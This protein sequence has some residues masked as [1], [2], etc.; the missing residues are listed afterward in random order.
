MFVIENA[1]QS[2]TWEALVLT[3]DFCHIL[4]GTIIHVLLLIEVFDNWLKCTENRGLHGGVFSMDNTWL[5]GNVEPS[6]HGV[7]WLLF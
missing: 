5:L 6:S 7:G 3:Y 1:L 4:Q 2:R